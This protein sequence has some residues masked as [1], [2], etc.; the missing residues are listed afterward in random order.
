MD[1]SENNTPKLN[2]HSHDFGGSLAT[3]VLTLTFMVKQL[4]CYTIYNMFWEMIF[5]QAM[6]IILKHGK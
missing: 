6:K 1:A 3:E 4:Q 5:L 2:T